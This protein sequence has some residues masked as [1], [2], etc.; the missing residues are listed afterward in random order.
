MKFPDFIIV[1]AARSGTT[2]LWHNLNLHPDIT[3]CNQNKS[4]FGTEINFWTQ[5]RSKSLDW[6]KSQFHGE[7]SGEKSP[8]YLIRHHVMKEIFEHIPTVKIVLILRNP[9]DRRYSEYLKQIQRRSYSYNIARAD[10]YLKRGGYAKVLQNNVLNF[11]SLSNVHI[12]INERMRANLQEE[13]NRLYDFLGVPHFESEVDIFINPG[14][15][16]AKN[17]NPVHTRITSYQDWTSEYEPMDYSL[18]QRLLK[19]YQ[20]RNEELFDLLGFKIPEWEH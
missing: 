5:N 17:E 6:Y 12:I 10:L 8:G 11:F 9:I 20:S 19:F 2:S 13:L 15:K 16:V 7:L 1:G 4:E 18:R 3:M 14:N